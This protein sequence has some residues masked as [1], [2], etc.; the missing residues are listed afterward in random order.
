MSTNVKYEELNEIGKYIEAKANE[1]DRIFDNI[2][3]I[4]DSVNDAWKGKDSDV[5]VS[6][7][8]NR[9]EKEKENNK[10]VRLMYDMIS[11][12]S[13][14]YKDKDLEWKSKMKNE[15]FYNEY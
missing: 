8:V 4:A 9:I 3:K 5:F 11:F 1:I 10:K 14:N 6:K 12:V 7:V 2:K 15:G 13:G